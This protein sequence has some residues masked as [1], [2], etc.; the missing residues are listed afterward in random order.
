M[1]VIYDEK[2]RAYKA[3]KITGPRHNFLGLVFSDTPAK[4]EAINLE[5]KKPSYINEFQLI[6]A[7]LKGVQKGNTCSNLQYNLEKI[8]YVGSDSPLYEAYELLAF[9]IVQ[10]IFRKK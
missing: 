10:E 7:V 3:V 5:E 6:D 1:N 9:E 8:L 2:D 4:L